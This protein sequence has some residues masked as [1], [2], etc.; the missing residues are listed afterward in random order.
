MAGDKSAASVLLD[1]YPGLRAA[2]GASSA[3]HEIR[4]RAA[5]EI[6]GESLYVVRGDTLGE[7]DDL[8]VDA[9][10][11][12]A[13]STS[14]DAYRRLFLELDPALRRPVEARAGLKPNV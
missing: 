6:D 13:V 12:G 2:M 3:F 14:D 1:T 4:A 7:E 9:L 11:R 10:V 5:L 8:Y